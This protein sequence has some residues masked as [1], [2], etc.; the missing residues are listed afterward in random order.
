MSYGEAELENTRTSMSNTIETLSD[1]NHLLSLHNNLVER[2]RNAQRTN[3]DGL[4]TLP[5]PPE[6]LLQLPL[7]R[8]PSPS[9]SSSPYLEHLQ[10]HASKR[11]TPLPS[12]GPRLRTDLPPEKRVRLARYAH[13][14]PEEETFR[15][16]Y[17]QRYVDGGD[18]PQNWVLG[19]DL[20]RRFEEY[21]KQQRLLQLKKAAVE[22]S[23]LPPHY[24]LLNRLRS[25]SPAKFDVILLDPP[26]H[27]P[28]FSWEALS[29]F[30]VPQLA[31]DPSFVFM[32]V[33]SGAGNGL[34]RGRE[35]L[36]QWGYRR[37]EDVVWVKT[38]KTSNKGPGTDPPTSSLLTRTKQHC[39][40]GIRGTVRRSTDHW[41]VHC[42]IDT[43]VIIWEGDS[44]DPTRKP[45]EMY[46][47]IESFCLGARRLEI[48]GRRR[49]A[50]PLRRGWVTVLLDDDGDM[51]AID[52]VQPEEKEV[53]SRASSVAGMDEEDV[54]V[55]AKM[56]LAEQTRSLEGLEGAVLWRREK[57]EKDIREACQTPIGARAVVVPSTTEIDILRPKSPTRGT[58]SNN[59]NINTGNLAMSMAAGAT[60]P[61][62]LGSMGSMGMPRPMS[63]VQPGF[64]GSIMPH[65]VGQGPYPYPVMLP[66]MRIGHGVM[67]PGL[68]SNQMALHMGVSNPPMG[69]PMTG[70]MVPQMGQFSMGPMVQQTGGIGM[71]MGMNMN[72]GGMQ[73]GMGTITGPMG[74]NM[75]LG[76]FGD[77]NGVQF[78]FPGQPGFTGGPQM[79]LNGGWGY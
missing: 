34:E 63:A 32:W 42:N 36:S 11:E 21:P 55:E 62:G 73:G 39:L 45:P 48:F 26:Y 28:S 27:S 2:V 76:G 44:E 77:V 12:R 33:G 5:S 58:T 60:L 25:M 68:M 30:P 35:V 43:D 64:S 79:N 24:L 38:N 53:D 47:L 6:S 13:Y 49:A 74:V 17:S 29:K 23:S 18:W 8:T 59:H 9:P 4:R 7:I 69:M 1:L 16:D 15:N 65:S 46:S 70:M 40:M 37:C 52:R 19:A 41:F 50:H 72:M 56:D 71:N 75:G 51:G 54:P 31:S 57:W 3:R 22:A 61:T 78:G 67:N 14:I 10:S 66:P 20:D